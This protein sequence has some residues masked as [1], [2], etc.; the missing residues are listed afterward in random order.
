MY[1]QVSPSHTADHSEG[2][3]DA[4]QAAIYQVAEILAA[5]AAVLLSR[6]LR[7][8]PG[9]VGVGRGLHVFLGEGVACLLKAFRY[10]HLRFQRVSRVS[11]RRG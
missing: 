8:P 5:E 10:T 6:R 11:M 4:V 3:D 1:S 7:N 2:S 9:I